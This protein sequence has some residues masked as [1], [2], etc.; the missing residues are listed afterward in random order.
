MS[1]ERLDKL[2]GA[3]GDM[4]LSLNNLVLELRHSNENFHTQQMQH[5][6]DMNELKVTSKELA[7]KIEKQ[8]GEI[9]V[10]KE[11][12]KNFKGTFGEMRKMFYSIAAG[13]MMMSIIAGVWFSI[14]KGE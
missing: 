2:E 3:I 1:E 10:L 5:K 6:E 11:S 13:L 7:E 9:A 8:G 4:T 14:T 12:T